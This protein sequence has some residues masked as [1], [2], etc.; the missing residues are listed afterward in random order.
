[1]KKFLYSLLICSTIFSCYA[2]KFYCSAEDKKVLGINVYIK[3][4]DENSDKTSQTKNSN[5]ISQTDLKNALLELSKNKKFTD[6][7]AKNYK[8]IHE[9][10]TWLKITKTS[11]KILFFPVR[12]AWYLIKKTFDYTVGKTV[13]EFIENKIL[14]AI[15][16]S[17]TAWSLYQNNP[18]VK[19]YVDL[20]FSSFEEL[21]VRLQQYFSDLKSNQN[22]EQLKNIFE[23]WIP[24]WMV[25]WFSAKVENE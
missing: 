4:T 22:A 13:S 12:V 20:A 1:M 2:S 18:T 10:P 5:K 3:K 16:A 8:K 19:T 24:D 6:E 7:V 25:N 23:K 11:A 17:L 14:P 9:D 15:I 21:K